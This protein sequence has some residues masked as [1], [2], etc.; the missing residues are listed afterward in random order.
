MWEGIYL[1]LILSPFSELGP[2]WQ[3][4]IACEHAMSEE[5]LE[6]M[7]EGAGQHIFSSDK[8]TTFQNSRTSKLEL[9]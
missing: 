3:F 7:T 9:Y 2:L 6:E 8:D 1:G 5:E 4:S